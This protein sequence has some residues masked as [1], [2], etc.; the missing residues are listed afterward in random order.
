M[1]MVYEVRDRRTASRIGA[2]A[3]R[4]DAEAL[5]LDVLRV[6]GAQA[7]RDWPCSARTPMLRT[8]SPSRSWLARS[9][10]RAVGRPCSRPDLDGGPRPLGVTGARRAR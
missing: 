5:L 10:S 1:A 4:Q 8:K 3:T 9:S 6:N 7:A 2:L